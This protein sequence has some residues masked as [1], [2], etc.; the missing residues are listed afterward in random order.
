MDLKHVDVIDTEP[1]QAGF[2]RTHD[3][4]GHV[5]EILIADFDLGV[6]NR[7]GAERLQRAAEI[8]FGNPIAVVGC[9]VEI[10]DAEF[11]GAADN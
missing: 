5:A 11:Q 10:G 9:I 2:R 8:G 1:P 7:T 3:M 4:A 6:E